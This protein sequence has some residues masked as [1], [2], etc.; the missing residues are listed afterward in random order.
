MWG[1]KYNKAHTIIGLQESGVTGGFPLQRPVTQSPDVFC[2][3]RLNRR[4]SKKYKEPDDLRRRRARYDVT[5]MVNELHIIV[6]SYD[7]LS[8]LF[9][10]IHYRLGQN[11]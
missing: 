6:R 10:I 2:D 11:V 7:S 5:I 1:V 8:T 4:L 9:A 3:L